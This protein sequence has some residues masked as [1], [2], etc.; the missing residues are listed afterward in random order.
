MGRKLYVGNLSFRVDDATL[1]E[2]FGRAGKVETATIVRDTDTGRARGFGFVEMAT[3]GEAQQA[4]Q[5]LNQMEVDGR[6]IA[7]N[8]ARPRP[9]R[10]SSRGGHGRGP[11]GGRRD[12]RGG[13]GKRW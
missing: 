13:Y 8:E 11:S 6:A 12:S 7:V 4:I 3:D 9:D 1:A 2:L 10:G 5:M